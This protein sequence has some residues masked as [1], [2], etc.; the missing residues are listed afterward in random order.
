MPKNSWS[1]IKKRLEQNQ[2]QPPQNYDLVLGETSS[3]SEGSSYQE[4]ISGIPEE[5]E[6]N[7]G[8]GEEKQERDEFYGDGFQSL[9]KKL[10]SPGDYLTKDEDKRDQQSYWPVQ[11]KKISKY[12]MNGG[13]GVILGLAIPEERKAFVLD[14]LYDWEVSDQMTESDVK[15]HELDH[16]E[17]NKSELN[18][19]IR[20][21]TKE[22]GIS[23][24][25]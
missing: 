23:Y 3:E 2:S 6:L 17:R 9:K 19:R 12:Q 20:T 13:R 25:I 5:F 8:E 14:N 15:R 24:S 4:E 16:V 18:T 10:N 22:K 1:T 21:N 7:G 11:V